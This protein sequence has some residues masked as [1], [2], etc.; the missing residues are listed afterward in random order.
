MNLGYN[1]PW[2]FLE[3]T[4]LEEMAPRVL[5]IE[6]RTSALESKAAPKKGPR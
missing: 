1:R 5:S 4:L 6:A 2:T 3:V